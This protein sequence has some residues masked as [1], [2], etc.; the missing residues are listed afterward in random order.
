MTGETY[1]KVVSAG[2]TNLR[3]FEGR[4]ETLNKDSRIEDK[5]LFNV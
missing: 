5:D 3:V 2:F 4:S 1:Y